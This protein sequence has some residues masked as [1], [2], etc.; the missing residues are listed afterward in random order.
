MGRKFKTMMG[1]VKLYGIVYNLLN[2]QEL[3]KEKEDFKS[4][5]IEVFKHNDIEF[6]KNIDGVLNSLDKAIK[7]LKDNI[8]NLESEDIDKLQEN[9]IKDLKKYKKHLSFYELQRKFFNNLKILQI[10]IKLIYFIFIERLTKNEFLTFVKSIEPNISIFYYNFIYFLYCRFFNL[11]SD[12][13][14]S[15]SKNKKFIKN[16]VNNLLGFEI[17]NIC[18]HFNDDYFKI[19]KFP[20]IFY[21]NNFASFLLEGNLDNTSWFN[22]KQIITEYENFLKDKNNI[23]II[24]LQVHIMEMLKN[25]LVDFET[26]YERKVA[27]YTNYNVAK[28]LATNSTSLR[29]SSTDFMNDPTEGKILFQFLHLNEIDY[30]AHNKTFLSC[31][32]FNHNSLNQFRLYGLENNIPCSGISIVYDKNFFFNLHSI[33]NDYFMEE[34]KDV[35][36]NLADYLKEGLKI[37]LFRCIYLDSFTGHFEIA[38]RNRFT[39]YQ[40]MQDKKTANEAWNAYIKKIKFIELQIQKKI[41]EIV[42]TLK[43]MKGK[44]NSLSVNELKYINKMLKPLSYLIKHFS[45]QEEQECRMIVLD[46]IENENV[47]MDKDNTSYSYIEY[48]QPTHRDIRNIYI[49]LASSYRMVELLKT[50]KLN[51][52]EICPKTIISD[53]PYRI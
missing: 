51:N 22:K 47:I 35:I 28:L 32:T 9:K 38:R 7:K 52:I 21:N 44:R 24:L 11:N 30:D 29:L 19:S 1:Y 10:V 43:I 34:D 39:F 37:P 42:N 36:E 15:L 8:I 48:D 2:T 41:Q 20:S 18:T 33:Y 27:H 49:G 45:F 17:L 53:N 46:K 26:N 25:L 40:E 23:S 16:C 4:N 6:K 14:S 50:I 5:N 31:F 3:S 12:Y 13:I